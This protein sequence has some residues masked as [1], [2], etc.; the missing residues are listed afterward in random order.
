MPIANTA[1]THLLCPRCPWPWSATEAVRALGITARHQ[2]LVPMQLKALHQW[3]SLSLSAALAPGPTNL[4]QT[5]PADTALRERKGMETSAHDSARKNSLCGV[6]FISLAK[7]IDCGE[8]LLWSRTVG[9]YLE[10]IFKERKSSKNMETYIYSQGGEPKKGHMV[11]CLATCMIFRDLFR[12]SQTL[13]LL[14]VII[15]A[16]GY[17]GCRSCKC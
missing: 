12:Q 5:K 6:C 14:K 17:P 10:Q 7:S 2:F 9:L 16:C 13:G 1:L 3:I 8:G 11:L 15:K 4:V